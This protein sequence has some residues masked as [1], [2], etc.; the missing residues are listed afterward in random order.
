MS[1]AKKLVA[2]RDTLTH[3]VSVP[4]VPVLGSDA[5]SKDY[6]DGA[7][8]G[9]DA[10]AIPYTPTNPGDWPDPDPTDVE[11][12]LDDLATA[13]TIIYDT[14]VATVAGLNVSVAPVVTVRGIRNDRDNI[15][16]LYFD[17]FSGSGSP[18]TITARNFDFSIDIA[19][20]TGL[21]DITSIRPDLFNIA[22]TA[23]GQIDLLQVA[24][25]Q[26][27]VDNNGAGT[28]VLV[29]GVCT[30]VGTGVFEVSGNFFV[31]SFT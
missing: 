29:T 2:Y 9:I 13:T 21:T 15:L 14:N 3:Q 16:H 7:I 5:A 8:G 1:Q 23:N 25:M 4:L 31:S 19:A 18:I 22:G 26:C 24:S 17:T 27:R 12:A 11:E 10:P 6:V 28:L 30:N 20:V